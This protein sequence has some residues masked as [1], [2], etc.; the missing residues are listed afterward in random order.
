M[1]SGYIEIL[2]LISR[3][4][5]AKMRAD[6][7][8]QLSQ[9]GQQAA[10]TVSRNA[11]QARQAVEKEAVDSRAKLRQMERHLTKV[12]GEEAGK[13]LRMFR[14]LHLLR[15]QMLEGTSRAT[16]QAVADVV[17]FDQQAVKER[18][19]AEQNRAR[20]QA[21][22]ERQ[23]TLE[24]QRRI[25]AEKAEERALAAEVR[26]VKREVAQAARQ[27]AAEQRQAERDLA[28]AARQRVAEERS[29]I[30][31]RKA[32][33]Q[34]ELR[35]LALQRREYANTITSNQAQL[36]AFV[37]ES[38][39]S[40][41][42]AGQHWKSLSQST[43][44]FGT[45]VEQIGRTLT[46][47]LVMPLA[48]AAGYMTKIGS[49]SADMQFLASRG[50]ERAGFDNKD[51]AESIKSIQDFAVKTPFSLEDMTDKFQQLTR[52]F[53][54]YGNTTSDSLKKSEKLIRAIADFAASYGV[55]D[56]ERVK[57]AMYSADMMMDMSKLN[58]RSLKQ[59]S[60]GT[61]I[62]INEL[63]KMAGFKVD[64]DDDE[65]TEAKEF[66]AKVQ[67]RGAGISSKSF[68]E[69]FL[70]EYDTRD[71][72]QGT[73][74]KLG[75]GSIG[76]HLQSVKEQAQLNFGKMF[77]DFNPE[78]G[79]FE[80]TELGESVHKLIDRFDGLLADE[81]FQE[82]SGGLIRNFVKALHYL[83]S[84]VE[85]TAE[86]LN[87]NP[88][89]KSLV[90]KAAKVAAVL[91]PLSIAIGMATKT[92]GKV[93]KAFS[94]LFKLVGGLAKGTRGV[95][96][97]ANQALAGVRAGRGSYL[98][99][100]RER[101]AD[102]HDGD[103]RSMA[104]RG[105][106]RARGQ[107]SRAEAVRLNTQQAEAALREV[108]RK[109]ETVKA[110]IRALNDL[111][112]TRLSTELGGEV[113]TSV[114]AG[115]RDAN[116]KIESAQRSVQQLNQAGLG[117]IAAKFQA[118]SGRADESERQ[119]KQ[120]HAAVRDLNDGKL[121]MVRQQ[122]EYLKDKADTARSR[123]AAVKSE[124]NDL[125]DR[126][127]ASLRKKFAGSLTPAIEGSSSQAKDLNSKIKDVNG[128]GLGQVTN[129]VR[130]LRDALENAEKKASGLETKIIAV[131]VANGGTGGSGGG[132]GKRRKPKGHAMGGVLPGY[133]P[134]VDSIPAILSPGEA[135]LRP[136]VAHHL[137]ATTINAW[138]AAAARGH[139]SRHAKGTAGKGTRKGG[140]WPLSIL[141]EL[142]SSINMGPALGAFDGGLLMARA[143]AG[144]GGDTGQ[145]LR[146]WGARQGGDAAGRSALNRFD[147]M[148]TFVVDRVPNLLRA[149]PTGIG[150]IIG[151]VA[152]A[153]APTAS[154]Y[155]W[156]DIWKGEGNIVERGDRF[157][158]HMLN[159]ASI[160]KMIQDLFGGLWETA[161]EIGSLA[162][163][164]AT[165]GPAKV[166]S[167]GIDALKVMFTEMIDGVEDSIQAVQDIASDPSEFAEEVF[168]SFWERA[169]EAMPNT[170]GLFDFADG[171]IVPGYSPGRDVVHARLSPGEAVL[172][173]EAVRALG[174]RA[175]LG[176]NRGA[177]Y[178][179]LAR[180]STP[181]TGSGEDTAPAVTPVPDAEAV[182]SAAQRIRAALEDM[183]KAVG[184]HQAAADASWSAISSS[185]RS[186]VD[187]EIRPAQQRWAQHLAGPLSSAERTF[188]ATH[189]GVW[190]AVQAR[191]STAASGS[192]GQFAR[193]QSGLG[194]LRSTFDSSSSAI[195]TSWSSSM[196]A[197]DA[198]TRSTIQGPYNSG[199]VPMLGA[200]AKLAGADA[201]LRTLHYS[202]GGVVPGY[203]PGIDRVPAVLSPG[204]G[205]L[206][207]EVVRALGVETIHEWNAAARKGRN[208]FAN[209]GVVNGG[210]WVDKHKDEPY[211][212]YEEAV[213]RGWSEVVEPELKHIASSF[214]TVGRLS[215]DDLRK[216]QP[217]AKAWGKYLDDHQGG[218]GKV[219][220]VARREFATEAP[221]TGGAKYTNGAVEAWCAD[222]VS[223][224]VDRAG[225]NAAYGN[226]PHGAPGNRWPA[227]AQWNAAMQHVPVA[228]ARPGD[229]LTYGGDA[230]INVLVG[231]DE[232]VGGNES[233]QLKR[234][235]GYWR[236][237]TAAL[238]PK[239]GGVDS[240][241]SF[242]PW[243]GS[244]PQSLFDGG[245]GVGSGQLTEWIQAAM[246]ATG[247]SGGAWLRGLVTLVM[248]ESGGNPRAVN[249]WDS[250][251]ASGDPSKGLAQVIGSTFRAY[252]QPGTSWD[253]LDPIANVA[254]AINYIRDRY[255]DISNVQQANP[256]LPPKGY[257]TG[258]RSAASGLALVGERGPELVNFRGGERVYPHGETRDLL[259][260]RYEI[261]IHEAKAEDTT[262]AVLRAMRY[263][264]AMSA[265]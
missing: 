15:E 102:Y 56:P 235:R 60:R 4:A 228:S 1:G 36:R 178:G 19:R 149:A 76:G 234:S 237:A 200:M 233:N 172:R 254:A 133:A 247:V 187:G 23:A 123:V 100:Y 220:E 11:K 28:A 25:A 98:S 224:V 202:A 193:L 135:I 70:K 264:E 124:V 256:D 91:G 63:A 265:H 3:E 87:D 43:E 127:L 152:G 171:G 250:N 208:V 148:R 109:I 161:K 245:G 47:N 12:H 111:P 81:G 139:L 252:H 165:D 101:R 244:I 16:K 183:T 253:I 95:A 211:A 255:G 119:V 205:V 2:P 263:A 132:E 94:P 236:S 14:N 231:P 180:S 156:D 83:L 238:R 117:E 9:L 57:S 232:T 93:G 118:L 214:A 40:T 79:R 227:V 49:Q 35:Q 158:G 240:G 218:G 129:R 217:W 243:P 260:P 191:V 67:E 103:D 201:P 229:L 71:G 20:E 105:L 10:A 74:E 85:W 112:L 177:K 242:N 186:A 213:G 78:T 82:L 150:N 146:A 141:D 137:G 125:N 160:W 167:E 72:V 182:E 5:V 173:P 164:I 179:T 257:W 66:L 106:D 181:D 192:L 131:N 32:A 145:N 194:T 116:Q 189:D 251:A 62:P 114:K 18:I 77:G 54:S 134:G 126:S 222:F 197:V 61:G 203:A 6:L 262:Q 17:R 80:W 195:R 73:A 248:R 120:V 50:L 97:T 138:N 154:Q 34:D 258:T 33:L 166:L 199:A 159:P 157:M 230:H 196:A 128:R 207:P 27:S 223:Y 53:Q 219:A 153:V 162:K 151:L 51:V 65:D 86:F 84:G 115:A 75:T 107:D 185:I 206:R 7:T 22:A 209:G 45:N 225:A 96:R 144:V 90:V 261:H 8:R 44:T 26:Q 241:P 140:P 99:T 39:T 168:Q 37:R 155:A 29:A 259:G 175:V 121:G 64:S 68:F 13:Q 30:Q 113:G 41:K 142:W 69:N 221:A 58:T 204:E 104:R 170:K 59:F 212:G 136:E 246:R 52:N 210:T 174:H 239:G 42:T 176:L 216:A 21:A 169:R 163:K 110:A 184:E 55:M 31:S 89:I 188:Q 38:G 24:T 190:S 198:S 88:E 122:V 48:A 226:S 108:D 143:G 92:F 130:T 147:N 46:Q 215:A 249:N